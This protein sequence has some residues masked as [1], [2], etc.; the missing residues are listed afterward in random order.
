[1][2]LDATSSIEHFNNW[3]N[4]TG[5]EILHEEREPVELTVSGCIPSY[6]SGT[7][8][9]TGPGGRQVKTDKGTTFA[10][11]HWFDGFSQ[12]HRFQI[13][14]TGSSARVMYNSRRSI[15][16][17]I[18]N[19]CRAGNMAGFSFGQKRDPCTSF[20]KK[21]ISVF[22]PDPPR[23]QE[24]V[25]IGVT[26]SINPPGLSSP[27]TAENQK[28]HGG[29]ASGIHTLLVKTDAFIMRHID[30]ETLEP[31]GVVS[32]KT[33]HPKLTGILSAAHAKSDPVT[34]DVHN[35]NLA[36]GRNPTYRVFRVSAA[37]G[38][39]EIL[40]TITDA[41]G[42]YLHSSLITESYFILCVWSG[43]YAGGGL[44]ILWEKNFLDA[45]SPFDPNQK[46]LWYVID[47]KQ[48]KGVVAKYECDP[49]FCFH[50]INAW[51][52]PSPTDPLYT[53]I[54]ADL[55]IYKNLDVLKRFYYNNIKSSSPASL[56]YA[57]DRRRS[58]DL[59]FRRWRL[60]SVNAANPRKPQE[61][62]V[63]HTAAYNH[64]CE[65]PVI[66]PCFLTK[67]SRYVYGACHRSLSTFFDGLVK[68]DV[69]TQTATYFS[70]HGHS[71][72][73]AI[74]IPNPVGTT[75][76]DGVLLSVVLDGYADKSYLLVLDVKTMKE[77]GRASMDFAVSFGFHGAYRSQAVEGPNTDI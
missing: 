47:R 12:N 50:T 57:G 74:F 70:V 14:Q 69:Q 23:P 73:E 36:L 26:L 56:D 5:F 67:Q 19:I 21:V 13:I 66:N 8:Y 44:K 9:R 65:F 37:T 68:Y 20:F 38:Q 1:M 46:A 31:R 2:T 63:V 25:N 29:H 27:Q 41:P 52:E 72:G 49:F 71:P 16:P 39:T 58:C 75:E 53:D 17:L 45:I 3:P 54:V 7:L 60:P 30:P 48:G 10:I 18:E 76:D 34:G 43:R 33:L 61:A 4:D 42:A 28:I 11:D 24:Q 51:E 40:A 59:F 22:V 55:S 77:V 32:Q 62:V 15:D 64:S 35:Y 6:V